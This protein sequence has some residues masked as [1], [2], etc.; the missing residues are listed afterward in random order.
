MSDARSRAA[1]R[2]ATWTITRA[3]NDGGV[4]P[5]PLAEGDRLALVDELSLRA[6]KLS[7]RPLPTYTRPDMP[8]RVIRKRR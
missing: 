3:S 6:W 7:G 5:V 1:A 2:R 4:A 8:G